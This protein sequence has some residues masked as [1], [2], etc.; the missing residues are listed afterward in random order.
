MRVPR[1]RCSFRRSPY[2]GPLEKGSSFLQSTCRPEEES[3]P[4]CRRTGESAREF[5]MNICNLPVVDALASLKRGHADLVTASA[6]SARRIRANEALERAKPEGSMRE[7]ANF[8]DV[9][10]EATDSLEP[11]PYQCR[12]ACGPGASPE[13]MD[14]PRGG[15]SCQSQPINVPTGLGKTG[16]VVFAGFWNRVLNPDASHEIS[17]PRRLVYCLQRGR[18]WSRHATGWKSGWRG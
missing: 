14:S 8:H 9:F 6:A 10:R 11:Y 15:A 7:S 3:S 13:D 12:L 17:W 1:R 18:S 4:R 2:A 5:G 16:A